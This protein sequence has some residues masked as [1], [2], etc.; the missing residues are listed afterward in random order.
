MKALLV[1]FLQGGH[2][3]F[4]VALVKGPYTCVLRGISPRFQLFPV[5]IYK[6]VLEAGEI[7]S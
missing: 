1:N 7:E 6:N 5:P 2:G 4:I 3:G